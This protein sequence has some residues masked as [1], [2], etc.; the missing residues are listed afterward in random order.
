MGQDSHK[1]DS[2][3]ILLIGHGSSLPYGRKVVFELAEM[4]EENSDFPVEVGFMNIEKP[5]I[6][7]AMNTL[8]QKGVGKI[9]AVPVFLAHGV[10][11][12]QDIKYMLGL[13]KPREDASYIHF[14]QED[15]E[16]NGEIVYIDP[17]GPDPRVADI[18]ED[19]VK[20]ALES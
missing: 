17:L 7:T 9:I 18:I 4:Y 16:F 3:G 8:S 2:I 11:T 1:K 5:T 15:I 6:R 19:R 20:D 12:K 10:H 14:N 13:G